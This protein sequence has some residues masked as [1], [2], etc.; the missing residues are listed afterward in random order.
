MAP[1]TATPMATSRPDPESDA[2]PAWAPR[3]RIEV[4]IL[5]ATGT[6]GQRFVELL[7]RHPWFELAWLGAS[8]RSA[9]RRYG[10]AC[11]WQLA[12]APPPEAAG[13]VVEE[14]VP[15]RAPRLVFSSMS[16]EQAGEIE[17]AFARAGH[18]VVSNSSHFR[19]EPD[20][21]LLVP[22]INLPHLGLLAAQRRAR[23]WEGAVVTNPNCA[24]MVLVMA[25]APL[26][27][28]GLK[29]VVATTFQAVSG[30]GYPGVPALDI[31][32]N[33]VPWIRGEEEKLERE[34]QKILGELA[35]AEVRPLPFVL[36]AA[37]NRVPAIDGHLVTASLELEDP[38]ALAAL[39]AALREFSGP[40]QERRLPSAPRRPIH[41]MTEPDRPQTRKDAGLEGGMATA[42]GRLRPCPVLHYRLVALSHNVLRGAA[43]AALLNAELMVSE[44]LV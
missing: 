5:G 21:P 8:D 1:S 6:V 31:L 18:L 15:G 37:C 28:F 3:R 24:A 2:P 14:C 26:R 39:A 35:G 30:A 12:G 32:G 40:P 10:E 13:R 19:M 20:V 34:P 4:G 23:G 27:R 7:D 38:P 11:S 25:L 43:G 44:G 36:S 33:V 29:R 16:S 41:L 22:E 9:G 42:V 17:A